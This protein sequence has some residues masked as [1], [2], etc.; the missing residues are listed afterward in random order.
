MFVN[1]KA[2]DQ[3][4]VRTAFLEVPALKDNEVHLIISTRLLLTHN[5]YGSSKGVLIFHTLLLHVGLIFI[6]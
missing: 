2:P 5:F 6:K 1:L 3:Q 4:T